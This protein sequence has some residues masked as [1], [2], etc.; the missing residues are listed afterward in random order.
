MLERV[1]QF[2]LVLTGMSRDE[3]NKMAEI[4]NTLGWFTKRFDLAE[5]K[6]M[7]VKTLTVKLLSMKD[8]QK[9]SRISVNCAST[10]G[11]L[12]YV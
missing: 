9:R 11:R 8:G 7:N 3:K 4:K 2:F 10:S 1:F 6:I 12:M 5:E